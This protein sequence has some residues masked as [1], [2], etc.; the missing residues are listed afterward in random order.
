[1]AS[2][3]TTTS[4]TLPVLAIETHAR[5]MG[6]R[7]AG[8][9]SALFTPDPTQSPSTMP[10]HVKSIMGTQAI[11]FPKVMVEANLMKSSAGEKTLKTRTESCLRPTGS[12]NPPQ[13]AAAPAR[14]SNTIFNIGAAEITKRFPM[15]TPTAA[16]RGMLVE[17]PAEKLSS[18]IQL[19]GPMAFGGP[20]GVRRGLV[21]RTSECTSLDRATVGMRAT[22][23]VRRSKVCVKIMFI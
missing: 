17:F 5:T 10:S 3:L 6:R 21:N 9:S 18:L 20:M 13:V 23:A 12:M 22:R 8:M 2:E 1:M 16:S 19:W 15:E 7:I 4:G 11:R 14:Q